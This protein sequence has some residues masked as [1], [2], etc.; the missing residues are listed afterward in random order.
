MNE[1]VVCVAV[2]PPVLDYIVD[3]TSGSGF[4][5][6]ILNLNCFGWTESSPPSWKVFFAQ[7]NMAQIQ[8][9]MVYLVI[10]AD[11]AIFFQQLSIQ[12]GAL[13]NVTNGYAG[14]SGPFRQ[15]GMG[16]MGIWPRPFQT[17]LYNGLRENNVKAYI[18]TCSRS[19]SS[20][21]EQGFTG[22]TASNSIPFPNCP[23][24]GHGKHRRLK[25]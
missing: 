8:N 12:S 21:S 15:M 9:A 1:L 22:C 25:L 10:E 7:R 13:P 18:W 14:T 4:N 5:P 11:T 20:F 3:S 16:S 23:W 19:S 17:P 24:T 6:P 2:D